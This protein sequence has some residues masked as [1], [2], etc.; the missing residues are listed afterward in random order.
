VGDSIHNALDGVLMRGFETLRIG[1]IFS[2]YPL[3]VI[4]CV[5]LL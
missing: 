5:R 4:F 3:L 2:C 1:W